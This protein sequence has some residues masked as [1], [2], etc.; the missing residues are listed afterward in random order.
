[1]L[2]LNKNTIQFLFWVLATI[3]LAL[4]LM[5]AQEM[6]N[7]LIF[8]DK[9]QHALCFATLTLVGLFAYRQ[10]PKKVCIGLCIY[11]ALIELMQTYFTSTRHGDRLDWLADTI[12]IVVGLGLF[13]IIR[14]YVRI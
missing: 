10:Q 1:M 5:P 13:L 8:W 11:G 4:T 6:P 3:T 2:K 14:R 7:A 12:G 9:L